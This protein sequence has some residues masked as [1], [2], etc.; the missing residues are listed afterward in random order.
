MQPPYLGAL[1]PAA[2][3]GQ[4]GVH[5]TWSRIGRASTSPA[6]QHTTGKREQKLK[7][8]EFKY[9]PVGVVEGVGDAPDGARQGN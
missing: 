6:P 8:P 2:P 9:R 5:P 1:G 3:P 4:A 7:A